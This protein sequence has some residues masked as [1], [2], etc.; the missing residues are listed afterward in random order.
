MP[1]YRRPRTIGPESPYY[2]YPTGVRLILN[3]PFEIPPDSATARFQFG[4]IVARNAVQSLEA[5]C[6]FEVDTVRDGAQ[7]VEPDDFVVTATQRRIETASLPLAP[8]F[9]HASAGGDTFPFL[10]FYVTEFRLRSAKQPNVRALHCQS[11]QNAPSIPI[12]RH[13]TLPEIRQAL[14]DWFN[15]QMPDASQRL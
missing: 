6:I 1:K 8:R 11:N 7:R 10:Y 4:R 15:L 5:H 9:M 2:R 3:K 12:M 14:G 13:L